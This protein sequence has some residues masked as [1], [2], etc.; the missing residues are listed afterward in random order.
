MPW[1]GIE[2]DIKPFTQEPFSLKGLTVFFDSTLSI[3][4]R[5]LPQESVNDIGQGY[6][7]DTA[8]LNCNY[9]SACEVFF[10]SASIHLEGICFLKEKREE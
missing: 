8:V 9:S 6:V 2:F 4:G 3:Q 5:I 7:W 1:R 10:K